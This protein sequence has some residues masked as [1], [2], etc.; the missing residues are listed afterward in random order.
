MAFIQSRLRFLPCR[1]HRECQL[2]SR[3]AS[4]RFLLLE[5]VGSL[6]LPHIM[7]NELLVILLALVGLPI[8]LTADEPGLRPEAP[9]AVGQHAP[10]F[11]IKDST[12]KQI[13]LAELTARGPV[14]VRL[15]C[16]CLGCDKELPYFQEV[17][18]AYAGQGLTSLAIFREPD[19]KVAQ[20]VR[21]K[22][23]NML[24]A[25]DPKGESW[26][27]FKT[28]TMPINFLIEKGGKIS[29]VAAGCDTSGLLAKRLSEKAAALT[30]SQVVD[31]KAKVDAQTKGQTET[32]R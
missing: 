4:L 27:V 6:I 16:G 17:Q 11:K 26:S 30:G 31:V 32:K 12:G 10:D 29:A 5:L 21:E 19:E 2:P 14:L 20:Y 9:L 24:Y 15:T 13:S 22:K 28:K 1:F 18:R 23:L 3:V 8:A 7:K 25:V